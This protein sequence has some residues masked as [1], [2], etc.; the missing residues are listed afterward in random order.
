MLQG[1]W[2]RLTSGDQKAYLPLAEEDVGASLWFEGCLVGATILKVG[3][4]VEQGASVA[5]LQQPVCPSLPCLPVG[6]EHTGSRTDASAATSVSRLLPAWLHWLLHTHCW[7][8]MLAP[9]AAPRGRA[10]MGS[11]TAAAWRGTTRGPGTT[12][13]STRMGTGR[14]WMSMSCCRC[15]WSG[16]SEKPEESVGAWKR[17]GALG[18]GGLRAAGE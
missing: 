8:H 3:Q 17:E 4:P 1:Y 10:S 5:E 16:E 9:H 14:T 15:C 11:C 2:V 13:C 7:P 6:K 18:A 12:A